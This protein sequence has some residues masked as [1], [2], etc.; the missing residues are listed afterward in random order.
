MTVSSHRELP[1]RDVAD[2]IA[3]IRGDSFV[4]LL[5][6]VGGVL[7]LW[8]MTRL[9]RPDDL[10]PGWGLPLLLMILLLVCNVAR[11]RDARLASMLFTGGLLAGPLVLLL[12]EGDHAATPFLLILAVPIAGSL[13]GPRG[14]VLTAALASLILVFGAAH[15][16]SPLDPTTISGALALIW[17]TALTSWA[18]TRN[19]LTALRWA[20]QNSEQAAR[21]LG[22]ARDYQ[23]R[24]STALRQL[25]EANYRLERANYALSRARVEADE[26]RRLKA[27]FAAHVSH[28][29]RT[30]INL[31]VGFADLML[32]HPE[33]YGDETL[34]R[35]YLTD[36][37]ALH[38]SARHLRGLID[39]ILDLAQVDAG[40]MPVLKEP[41]D[42]TALIH[43]AVATARRLLERKCLAVTVDV[44]SDLPV[45]WLDRLRLRQVVLN[46]LNNAARFTE[47]GGV[48]VRARADGAGAASRVVVE[49]ADTGLGI[50]EAD[51]PK[52]FRPFQQ[53]DSS[54]TRGH[55]GTG[56]GLVIS[57]RFVELHGGQIWV[58]SEG[59]P[60]RGSVF[61]FALPVEPADAAVA[62]DSADPTDPRAHRWELPTAPPEPSVV[63]L[64]DDPA[65]VSLFQRHLG[66]YQVVGAS[67]LPEAIE[68]ARQR[69]ARAILT[70]APTTE[71]GEE[72]RRRWLTTVAET[73]V[74]V[75]GG[76]MPSGRRVARAL[77]LVDYLVKPVTREA[78]LASVA[79]V[80]PDARTILVVDDEP[81]LVRLFCRM[82]Q[83]TNGNYHLLRAFDGRQALEIAR[84]HRP[85]LV[86]L[87][88]LMPQIDGLTVL[89]QVR[90]D[91]A[92]STTPVIAVSARGA[93]EAIAPSSDRTLTLVSDQ[94]LP[95]S[96]LIGLLAAIL[97]AL[98]LARAELPPSA[99]GLPAA[100]GG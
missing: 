68:L 36:L 48:T 39:D 94:P 75:I 47:R 24:L 98:P 87:D 44:P 17:L 35:P 50:K 76:P 42:L 25:E 9:V 14:I 5:L 40:E 3:A 81:R 2:S 4:A 46:L 43:D 55:G 85:D 8:L 79:A 83:G 6:G 57:K 95:V 93:V 78:L 26:A 80:A 29:L 15:A 30:P 22:E 70:D 84:E 51:R 31:V 56:L 88:L 11:H 61:A 62:G 66:G 20:E 71:E 12:N 38:R 37:A 58:Q 73:G 27:Q 33:T 82:L 13:R 67:T 63:V 77:G 52:L 41:T 18:T 89:E 59:I 45:L 53:L 90:Q 49:I 96:R 23:A 65:I 99:P 34:P 69:S 91:P 60:G 54:P 19:L 10:W 72:W 100:G 92:L 74:P 16:P 32:N 97:D 21:N 64:D 7:W 28:E 1:A 86:L